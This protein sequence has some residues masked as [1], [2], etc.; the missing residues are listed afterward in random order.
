[1]HRT[2]LTLVVPAAVFGCDEGPGTLEPA[3][4]SQVPYETW[5]CPAFEAEATR[6]LEEMTTTGGLPGN[7]IGEL[8]ALR[9]IYIE[10]ACGKD[11]P[12]MVVLL[13]PEKPANR[14]RISD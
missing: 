1:M 9:D 3:Y 4:I 10:K 2:I 12:G 14:I 5:S 6:I 7:T 8:M 11:I 13:T